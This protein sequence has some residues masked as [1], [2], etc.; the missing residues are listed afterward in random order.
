MDL[1]ILE[2]KEGPPL[3]PM[4][5]KRILKE[6]YEKFYADK[7]GNQDE[8]DQFLEDTNCQNSIRKNRQSEYA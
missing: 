1:L 5:I 6:Y 4:G 7:F 2:I 3:G 8:M